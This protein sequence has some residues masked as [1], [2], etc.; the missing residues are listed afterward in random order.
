MNE[1]TTELNYLELRELKEKE[2][3]LVGIEKRYYN[4][5][6]DECWMSEHTQLERLNKGSNTKV[7]R[8]RL[9]T[10]K[11]KL[12]E[13]GLLQLEL[14][15]NGK[16]NNLKHK[17]LKTIPI[18]ILYEA[19]S[20]MG[21]RDNDIKHI[22][23]KTYNKIEDIK[24]NKEFEDR[25]E[26][27]HIPYLLEDNGFDY[28]DCTIDIDWY[29]LQRYTAEDLNRMS[30]IELVQLYMDCGFVVLPTHYPIFTDKGVKCSCKK[31]YDC[32]NKGKHSKVYYKDI[33]SFN[34]Q[35]YNERHLNYFKKNP[36]V[37][38]GFKVMGYSVLDV[39]NRHGGDQS[40]KRLSSEYNINFSHSLTVNCSNGQHIYLNNINL[41]NTA[42]VVGDGLDIRSE[43]GFLVAPGSVHKTEKTYEWNLI[44]KPSTIPAEWV[45][46]KFDDKES[47]F[48]NI[49]LDTDKDESNIEL[50]F[51]KNES[52][53]YKNK[54]NTRSSFSSE[55]V[56]T[57]RQDIKLP[58]KLTADYRIPEGQRG[59]TL[60]GW[61]CRRR[62]KGA[63]AEELYEFLIVVRDTY[64]EAGD[65]PV[66]DAEIK[67]I[68]SS[69]SKYPTNEE[70]RSMGLKV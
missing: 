23:D 66:T 14:L 3:N 38:I 36:D 57:R 42:G 15:P 32:P 47:D 40:L 67:S 7:G 19:T 50:D 8:S 55:P 62:G 51:D 13:Q 45:E 46:P 33:N 60:F 44:G 59:L 2:K 61:A 39:D 6:P 30:K 27:F 24:E 31:E 64:C 16:R 48:D 1:Q 58:F 69:A 10:T 17:L 68:A 54:E 28:G 4:L 56:K 52:N 20:D 11:R 49:E 18:N 12:I 9:R 21:E 5:L 41:K 70:K 53:T 22:I 43:G 63:N 37:N 34:Y 35:Y 65:A 29:L 26:S 25:E